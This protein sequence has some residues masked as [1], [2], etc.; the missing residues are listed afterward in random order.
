MIIKSS[1][2]PFIAVIIAI[3]FTLITFVES[4]ETCRRKDVNG[5]D[6]VFSCPRLFESSKKKFCCGQTLADKHCCEWSQKVKYYTRD[7]SAV[8]E[9]F[10]GA[11]T[12]I[13]TVLLIIAAIIIGCCVC[14]CCLMKKKRQ[15]RGQ[16]L[17]NP[18]VE[19]PSSVTTVTSHPNSYAY[20]AQPNV[21]PMQN[22]TAPYP[23]DQPPPYTYNS[24]QPPYNPAYP[25][26]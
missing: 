23:M 6:D 14:G 17:G 21:Y 4:G 3:A 20:P 5:N 19:V 7:P 12:L 1:Y 16:V 9:L 25:I 2:L 15:Q 22:V 24:S 18:G 8:K 11:V 26:K 13:I 10:D